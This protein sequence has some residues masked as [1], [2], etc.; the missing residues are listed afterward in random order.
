M[1][2]CQFCYEDDKTI[3]DQVIVRGRPNYIS[4]EKLSII[5]N[6]KENNVCKIIKNEKSFGTGFLC[7]I[8]YPDKLNLLPVLFTCNHVLG[9]EEIKP[10]KEIKLLFNDKE[11]KVIK[12]DENRKTYISLQN[13]YD[14][15]IIEIRNNDGF[16]LNKILE[17]DYDIY[18][19]FPL[20]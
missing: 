13:E 4:F 17:I 18:E 6:Q 9:T 7:L 5:N 3:H 15:T 1:C 8:P 12:I 20:D 14:T 16:N 19:P 11:I 10:G 2:G